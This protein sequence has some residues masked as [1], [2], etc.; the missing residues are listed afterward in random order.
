MSSWT[1]LYAPLATWLVRAKEYSDSCLCIG[2]LFPQARQ[3]PQVDH[4]GCGGYYQSTEQWLSSEIL[5]DLTKV[6]PALKAVES[7]QPVWSLSMNL[8]KGQ[9]YLVLKCLN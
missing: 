9:Q 8:L 1:G 2:I 4:L 6:V 3:P 5:W 7:E